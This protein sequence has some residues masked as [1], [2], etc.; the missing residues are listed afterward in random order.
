[1]KGREILK[2]YF[3]GLGLDER[4][5]DNLLEFFSKNFDFRANIY[6]YYEN[7]EDACDKLRGFVEGQVF[8]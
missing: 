4:Y 7:L 2:I 5:F 8:E 3:F 6:R 1:L